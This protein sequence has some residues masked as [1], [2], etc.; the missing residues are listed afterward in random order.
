MYMYPVRDLFD[1][2]LPRA[3]NIKREGQK[4][5]VISSGRRRDYGVSGDSRQFVSSSSQF[6]E[7]TMK[8]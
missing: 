6:P 1:E 8:H 4:K 2:D 5:H 7:N 3:K